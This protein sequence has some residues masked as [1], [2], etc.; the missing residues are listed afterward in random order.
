MVIHL[1]ETPMRNLLR[2]LTR[3]RIDAWRPVLVLTFGVYRRDYA[4]GL[5]TPWL[6]VVWWR[7]TA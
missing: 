7:D 6:H 5:T 4:Y 2:R 3:D 1:V